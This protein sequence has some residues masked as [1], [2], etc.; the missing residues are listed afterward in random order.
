MSWGRSPGIL[1]RWV[2][3]RGG[4]GEVMKSSRRGGVVLSFLEAN[5]P[6]DLEKEIK[7]RESPRAGGGI[8]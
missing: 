1:G 2:R 4:A 3:G 5:P 8:P 7:V 6:Q